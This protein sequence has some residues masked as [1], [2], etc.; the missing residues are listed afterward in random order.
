MLIKMAE[1]N[2]WVKIK[3][4]EVRVPGGR[5]GKERKRFSARFWREE[6]KPCKVWGLLGL[7]AAS[8]TGRILT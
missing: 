4:W 1:T 8:A 2:H 5:G 7:V 3:R 6:H